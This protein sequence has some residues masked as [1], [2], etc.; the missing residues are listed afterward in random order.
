[1]FP[2]CWPKTIFNGQFEFVD[3]KWRLILD[4]GPTKYEV[5][6]KNKSGTILL[7]IQY[8]RI[9]YSLTKTHYSDLTNEEIQNWVYPDIDDVHIIKYK[10][11]KDLNL[12]IL[13]YIIYF[14]L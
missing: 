8:E 5:T 10:S 11:Y 2:H 14:D 4:C 9:N 3:S 13:F 1:M 12:W 6:Y 7:Q